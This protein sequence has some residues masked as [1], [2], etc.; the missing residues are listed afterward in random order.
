MTKRKQQS[1]EDSLDLIAS[2]LS[3][4]DPLL[5]NYLSF[6]NECNQK[7]QIDSKNPHHTETLSDFVSIR[8]PIPTDEIGSVFDDFESTLTQQLWEF[9]SVIALSE[10]LDSPSELAY[11]VLQ[12]FLYL[13]NQRF[14][15]RH[16]LIS[17]LI[18]I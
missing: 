1:T 11:N 3:K 12:V 5:Q 17:H 9:D 16:S 6:V 14:S 7:T 18:G 15:L 2:I 10:S 8:S 4:E 13:L